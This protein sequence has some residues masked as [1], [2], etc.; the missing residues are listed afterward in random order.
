VSAYDYGVNTLKPINRTGV[1]LCNGDID[2]LPLWY[3]QQVEGKRPEVITLTMQLMPYDWYRNAL[4]DRE[5]FL[6][7]SVTD[8]LRPQT[9]VQNM[10]N[11]HASER[12]FY[13]SSI[14][15]APWLFQGNPCMAEGFV[16]RLL[17]TKD[18]NGPFS[19]ER[20]NQLWSSF[21]L[22][23]LDEPSRGHWDEYSD[24]MKDSYGLG[25]EL[26]GYDRLRNGMP[27]Q[28]IWALHNALRF[29]ELQPRG[30]IHLGL[31]QMYF[32]IHDFQTA[33]HEA[34]ESL[35]IDP[36]NPAGFVRMGD[37]QI[38]LGRLDE[39]RQSYIAALHL[40]PQLLEARQG[41]SRIDQLNQNTA[42]GAAKH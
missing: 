9:V 8:D 5:P 42:F 17:A 11:Q 34:R 37:A 41:M 15:I 13:F 28:S 29:R 14:F 39:A 22:R 4:F 7:V 40:T 19:V 1:F 2:L 27:T 26:M 25:S 24:I 38:E 10:I 33:L 30:V 20:T 18:L 6:K 23:C 12:S 21:R 35:K 3:L 16:W 31:S 32:G 36:G